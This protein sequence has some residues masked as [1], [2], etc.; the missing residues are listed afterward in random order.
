MP[1]IIE[2]MKYRILGV[3]VSAMFS[4]GG[5]WL[6]PSPARRWSTLH[7][8]TARPHMPAGWRRLQS[9]PSPSAPRCVAWQLYMILWTS[10][11]RASTEHRW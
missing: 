1:L 6:L 7:A 9:T 3:A 5:R 4:I 10:R 2:Y 8:R 11:G